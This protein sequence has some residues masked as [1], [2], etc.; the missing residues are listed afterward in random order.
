MK[1]SNWMKRLDLKWNPLY[2]ICFT[3][4]HTG[5]V[6]ILSGRKFLLILIYVPWRKV[7]LP[8]YVFNW[9]LL[10]GLTSIN[11][12]YRFSLLLCNSI[13]CIHF[14]LTNYVT[15]PASE[16]HSLLSNKLQI[17]TSGEH[18][19]AFSIYSQIFKSGVGGDQKK[20][21][22]FFCCSTVKKQLHF[23]FEVL[24]F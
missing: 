7:G 19:S 22:Y 24:C 12:I 4:A 16:E 10:F 21:K 18:A 8:T 20:T 6:S 15:Y 23:Y 14:H 9:K 17:T 5:N 3:L 2:N 1:E 13:V 11:V